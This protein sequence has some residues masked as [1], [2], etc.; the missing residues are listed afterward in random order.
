MTVQVVEHDALRRYIRNASAAGD[1]NNAPA[2][3]AYEVHQ[4]IDQKEV[5]DMIDEEL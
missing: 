4:L 5:A 1:K 3:V 2:T